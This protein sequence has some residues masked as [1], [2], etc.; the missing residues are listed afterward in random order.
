MRSPA[1]WEVA[2]PI[3]PAKHE[4]Y[5]NDK[6]IRSVDRFMTQAEKLSPGFQAIHAI[7][8]RLPQECVYIFASQ[9]VSEQFGQAETWCRLI[10]IEDPSNE[11]A[12]RLLTSARELRHHKTAKKG[13]K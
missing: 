3:P 7:G 6:R 5:Q 1:S 9:F 12:Q 13:K 2:K 8:A 4:S 10:L 11:T